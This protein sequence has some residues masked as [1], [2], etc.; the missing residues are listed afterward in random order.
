[1]VVFMRKG[2][3]IA[4]VVIAIALFNVGL[5]AQAR[6]NAEVNKIDAYSKKIDRVRKRNGS[7]DLVFADTAEHNSKKAKWRKFASEKALEKFRTRN[8]TYEIAYNWKQDGKIVASNFTLFSPSGDWAK[9]VFHYFRPDGSLAYVET[10]YRTFMGNFKVIRGRYFDVNGKQIK[11]T[12]RYLDLRSGKP[13]RHKD[14]VDGD[15]PNEVDYYKKVSK[16]PFARLLK[17]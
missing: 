13:K 2:C 16:L 8:E 17:K 9:Y 14:G 4:L 5:S 6:N 10:D 7:P 1:M 11:V 15:D 3:V 12:A